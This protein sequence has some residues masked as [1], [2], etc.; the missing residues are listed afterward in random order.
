MS[1]RAAARMLLAAACLGL[2]PDPGAGRAHTGCS[3]DAG[4]FRAVV[5]GTRPGQ[6][7]LHGA[8]GDGWV[9]IASPGGICYLVLRR[10]E[11]AP[12]PPAL[13]RDDLV[14]GLLEQIRR[15]EIHGVAIDYAMPVP[16]TSRGGL[17]LRLGWT[18]LSGEGRRYAADTVLDP[19]T[20]A[21]VF[22]ICALRDLAAA[23]QAEAF[24]RSVH[25]EPSPDLPEDCAP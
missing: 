10:P 20:G 23:P 7:R 14:Q 19:A 22:G 25:M 21:H 12:A 6:L 8:P 15:A 11:A 17:P 4:G 1:A 13:M 2:L 9:Q 18:Q 3:V 16:E 24:L 5:P